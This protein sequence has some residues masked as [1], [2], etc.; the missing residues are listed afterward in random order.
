MEPIAHAT[1]Y[2]A[3]AAMAEK[4]ARKRVLVF[5]GSEWTFAEL[6]TQSDQLAASLLQLGIAPGD[7]VLLYLHNIR[8][9]LVAFFALQRIGA[10][11]VA[12]SALATQQEVLLTL[13]QTGARV[14]ICLDSHFGYVMRARESTVIETVIVTRLTEMLPW[15][16]RVVDFGLK[17]T[18]RGTFA[19]GPG[20]VSFGS[21]LAVSSPSLPPYAGK[22]EDTMLLCFTSGV[23]GDP[24]GI[25][26]THALFLQSCVAP[27]YVSECL[28]PIGEGV[29]L[30]G[31]SLC[32]C[33]GIVSALCTLI[34]AG[35]TLILAP[36]ENIDAFMA[37]IQRYRVTH[38]LGSPDLYR[39]FLQ[40]SRL[41]AYE[42]TS[43]KY[44]LVGG[45]ILPRG[46]AEGWRNR[47]EQ[48]LYTS[49]A[50]T[51]TCGLV[52]CC[53]PVDRIP[54][55]A[56]GKLFSNQSVLLV[57][58]QT[59]T[60]VPTGVPGEILVS[61]DHMPTAYVE[62]P[63]QTEGSFIQIE[64]RW[65]FRTGDIGRLDEDGWL[66]YLSRGTDLIHFRDQVIVAA[67]IERVLEA[68]PAVMRAAVVGIPDPDTGERIKSFLVLTPGSK[69]IN[70]QK[71][72]DW[73]REKMPSHMVPQY[74]EFRDML[75]T[76][77]EGKLLKREL[78]VQD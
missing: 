70:S 1:I 3:F 31:C 76:T 46:L 50:L 66:Y 64:G 33:L 75:P 78:L 28:V 55:G 72:M 19:R 37:A 48:D 49:Y 34:C 30:L 69:G 5:F 65:W 7:R 71:L 15:W 26:Y 6:R 42:M 77:K 9:W 27:R 2:E 43:L 41:D 59:L 44:C 35:E 25:P 16:K 38:L 17:T 54:T 68:H 53:P 61:S 14:V 24:K 45:D 36:E 74:I 10:V 57:D 39:G 63:A 51:E 58:P 52:A 18:S 8:Q 11:P 21:C 47:F 29:L 4:Q 32:E 23:Q 73:C 40:N 22:A 12:A 20:V 13:K 67:E 60:N 62:A 56:A